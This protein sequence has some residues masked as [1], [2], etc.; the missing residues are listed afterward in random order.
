MAT[1]KPS[2]HERE[3]EPANTNGAVSRLLRDRILQEAQEIEGDCRVAVHCHAVAASRWNW[4]YYLLGLPTVIL[5]ALAGASALS[6]HPQW[7]A[8]LAIAATVSAAA[9]TF[10]NAGQTASAHAKKRSEYEQ[11]K[12]EVR[13]FRNVTVETDRPERELIEE[14]T[15]H[16]HKR[17]AL[18]IES[19]QVSRRAYRNAK[20]NREP[21]ERARDK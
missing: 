11:L 21:K 2:G 1:T 6:E 12:N 3:R 13:H 4:A 18:N 17:D 8:G 10:L 20:Q 19:P 5:A 14:L 16:G 9:N 7:A 15:L